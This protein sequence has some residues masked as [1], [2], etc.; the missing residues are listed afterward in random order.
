MQSRPWKD[1]RDG[2]R[3]FHTL[4]GV[5]PLCVSKCALLFYGFQCGTQGILQIMVC[6]KAGLTEATCVEQQVCAQG[7]D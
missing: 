2:V 3:L 1:G 7:V 5:A 6:L 4:W